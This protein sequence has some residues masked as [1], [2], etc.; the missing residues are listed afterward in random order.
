MSIGRWRLIKKLSHTSIAYLCRPGRCR[1][2]PGVGHALLATLRL[3]VHRGLPDAGFGDLF[4]AFNAVRLAITPPVRRSSPKPA[5]GHSV[6]DLALYSPV[7][8]PAHYHGPTS[9]RTHVNGK[10]AWQSRPRVGT[11]PDISAR[12]TNR[13]TGQPKQHPRC[14]CLEAGR[15]AA[16]CL[17]G[18]HGKYRV[19]TLAL[20]PFGHLI[21]A[22]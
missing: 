10:M 2:Y 9:V 15:V 17:P 21:R 3:S 11:C 4:A 8:S 13:Q 12:Q 20:V 14:E 1:R 19:A 7:R 18:L 16:P 22:P 5:I 6:V